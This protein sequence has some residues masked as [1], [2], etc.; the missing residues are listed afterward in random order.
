ML[1]HPTADMIR[2]RTE[3]PV[4]VIPYQEQIILGAG[5]TGLAN[6]YDDPYLAT[7]LADPANVASQLQYLPK[8]GD[9]LTAVKDG[10]ND[11][12]EQQYLPNSSYS[13]MCYVGQVR[14]TGPVATSMFYYLT[15]RISQSLDVGAASG[16]FVPGTY[17]ALQ[18]S[19]TI[20]GVDRTSYNPA[21]DLYLFL[22]GV[23]IYFST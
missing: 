11:S 6:F 2:A 13:R 7:Y 20:F 1:Y 3:K 23:L 12:G 4:A 22:D 9:F 21:N 15:G 5:E 19:T 8:P 18:L 14:A 17:P 10:N 16:S